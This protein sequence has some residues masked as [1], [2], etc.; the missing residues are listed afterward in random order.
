M[1]IYMTRKR[2]RNRVELLDKHLTFA[3]EVE[4]LS[5]YKT[6]DDIHDQ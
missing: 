3:R 5:Y 2:A 4:Y 1:M 6:H